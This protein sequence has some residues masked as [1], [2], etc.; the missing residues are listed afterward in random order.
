MKKL[1]YLLF[2]VN[3]FSSLQAQQLIGNI[4]SQKCL[5]GTDEE[6]NPSIVKTPDGGYAMA[7]WAISTNGDL[8]ANKGSYDIWVTKLTSAGAI[9]W[10]KNYGGSGRDQSFKIINLKNGGYVIA[11]HTLSNDGDISGLHGVSQDG[12]LMKIDATGTLK[13]AK[14]FGNTGEDELYSV[15]EAADG[16]LIAV[17]YTN[18]NGGQV[19]GNHGMKDLWIVKT[20]SNGNFLWQKCY[21]GTLDDIGYAS[22]LATSVNNFFIVGSSSSNNGN[23]TANKGGTDGWLLKIDSAGTILNSI[24]NGGTAD[25]EWHD[26]YATNDAGCIAIGST[27]SNDMDVSGNHGGMDI[28]CGKYNNTYTF[29]WSKCIGGTA[30]ETGTTILQLSDNNYALCGS[31]N[32]NDINFYGTH[33]ANDVLVGLLNSVGSLLGTKCFG[34][35]FSEITPVIV[36]DGGTSTLGTYTLV[37]TTGS[38]NLDVSGNHGANDIWFAKISAAV[39][40]SKSDFFNDVKVYPTATGDVLNII[41]SFDKFNYSVI[42]IQGKEI[43]S[44][45]PAISQEVKLDCSDITPGVYV[46]RIINGREQAIYRFVKQ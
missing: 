32:S 42:D 5:G 12:L 7:S 34:G 9:S 6:L 28:W 35:G 46:L 44:N 11:G 2:F 13:W 15:N 10:Q 23:L 27:K 37:S 43:I 18:S 36:N 25:D 21:G 40:I 3:L 26:V 1:F 24:N 33:G 22:C 39:G 31:G 14:V 8:T 41:T 20:D 29:S 4:I 19:T 45:S 16:K 17:G 30:N 38:N